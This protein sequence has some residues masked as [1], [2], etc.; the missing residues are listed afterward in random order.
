MMMHLSFLT[1]VIMMI[2]SQTFFVFPI[3]EKTLQTPAILGLDFLSARNSQ[4]YYNEKDVDFLR[5]CVFL[6]TTAVKEVDNPALAVSSSTIDSLETRFEQVRYDPRWSDDFS[7]F[8]SYRLDLIHRLE[9]KI[10]DTDVSFIVV[11]PFWLRPN[12]LPA[13]FRTT[14]KLIRVGSAVV[15]GV[16]DK[17]F[18]YCL[19]SD[20]SD[21]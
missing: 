11:D 1:P 8:L 10:H 17:F 4:Q 7:L 15:S 3:Q 20:I 2:M 13:Q 19:S 5:K 18:Y 9:E 21:I 12:V 14:P 16:D 6:E